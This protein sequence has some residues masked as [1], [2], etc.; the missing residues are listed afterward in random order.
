MHA[1]QWSSETRRTALVVMA[2]LLAM[3]VLAAGCG[4]PTTTRAS[5]G[6]TPRRGG[7]LVVGIA[8]ETDGWNPAYDEWSAEGSLVGSTVL[9]PL[10]AQGANNGAVPWLAASWY[11]NTTFTKWV[12]NLQPHVAFQDGEPFNAAAV[13]QNLESSTSSPLTTITLGALFAGEKALGPL[14][15]EVDLTQPWAAFPSSFLQSTTA[16]MMAPKMLTSSDRGATHPIGTGP[17]TFSSWQPGSTFSATRN[18]TYWGGL[19][20][21]GHRRSGLPYLDSIQFKILP[22]ETTRAAALQ[23]GNVNVIYS[24]D[25]Q[26]AG[27]L[28]GSFDEIKDWT[29]ENVFIITNVAPTTASGSA[30]PL[31]NLHAR[32]AL[33]YATDPEAVTK[34]VGSGLQIASSPWS[35]S[36]PWGMPTS[37]NGYVSFDLAKA[38]AEVAAYEQQTG[39]SSLSFT[40]SGLPGTNLIAVL[41]LL[42]AQWKLAGITVKIESLTQAA[43]INQVIKGDYQASLDLNYGYPDPDQDY[44]FWTSS[45]AK[46]V[47]NLSV[48]FSQYSSPQI[49]KDLTIGRQS[50]YPKV[51]Q[52]AYDDLTRQLNAAFTHIW[53]YRTPYSIITTRTVHGLD[54]PTGPAHISFANTDPKTWFAQIWMQG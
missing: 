51:R 1:G 17:F 42:Q 14:Q 26:T 46:G 19:D 31:S 32:A 27:S 37:Q 2:T 35:P 20:A 6:G 49:D 43:Y 34:V 54:G 11:P 8:S 45:T 24:T 16:M 52:Q 15:V 4:H 41:Q 23:D 50:G 36:N 10:A 40:L 9:E 5:S 25:A 39:Q 18:P 47:G 28:A 7:S 22:D 3:T 30:N 33:A 13:V 44:Q 21:A 38:K 12:I 53:L 29:T 48:N